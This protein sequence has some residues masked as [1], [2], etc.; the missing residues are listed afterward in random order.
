MLCEVLLESA[1]WSDEQREVVRHED[2]VRMLDRDL[3][4]R[5]CGVGT[6]G[7]DRF[8]GGPFSQYLTL[9]LAVSTCTH[10]Y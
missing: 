7:G 8:S 9:R 5:H 10:A 3:V 2:V 4:S 6:G 1:V